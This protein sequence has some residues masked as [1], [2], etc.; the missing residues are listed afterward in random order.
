MAR[1]PLG[2]LGFLHGVND[3]QPGRRELRESLLRRVQMA[4]GGVQASPGARVLFRVVHLQSGRGAV[5]VL[6]S[7]GVKRGNMLSDK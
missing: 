3:R 7:G 1:L 2:L 4:D 5:L 6:R